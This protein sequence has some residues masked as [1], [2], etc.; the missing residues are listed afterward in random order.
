MSICSYI[1]DISRFEVES[2]L[3]LGVLAGLEACGGTEATGSRQET[4]TERQ[5][6]IATAGAE[7]MPFNLEATTHIFE[8]QADGGGKGGRWQTTA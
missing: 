6:A 8:K 5:E 2:Q 7:A 3:L 4:M 1:S